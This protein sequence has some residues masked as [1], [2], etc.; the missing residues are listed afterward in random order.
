MESSGDGYFTGARDL[1]ELQ[2]IEANHLA[3]LP[4]SPILAI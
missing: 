3:A 1:A 4:Q 2:L